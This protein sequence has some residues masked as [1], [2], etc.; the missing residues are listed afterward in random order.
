MTNQLF[1]SFTSQAKN[2]SEPMG[3]S[4]QALMTHFEKLADF[5]LQTVKSYAELA[6]NQW[7]DLASVRDLE[8]LQALASKNTELFKEIS[9]K[10]TEDMG[11]LSEIGTELKDELEKIFKEAAEPKAEDVVK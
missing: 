8:S 10:M 11:A 5:Q 9:Q 1:E 7:K 4:Y 2:F 6:M 3:K